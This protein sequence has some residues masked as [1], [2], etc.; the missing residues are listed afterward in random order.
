VQ[1]PRLRRQVGQVCREDQ[2]EDQMI[3]TLGQLKQLRQQ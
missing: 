2:E 1:E 3:G